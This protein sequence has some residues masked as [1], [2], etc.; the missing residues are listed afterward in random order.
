[1]TEQVASSSPGSV[2]YISYSMF[3]E[4]TI[5]LVPSGFSGWATYDLI[6]KLYLLAK[7]NNVC[8]S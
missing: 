7:M 5:R 6:Q 2:G 8:T 4:P 3:I 1:M